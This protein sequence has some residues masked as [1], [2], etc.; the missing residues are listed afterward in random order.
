MGKPT[1]DIPEIEENYPHQ[2]SLL[3]AI[4]HGISDGFSNM[5]ICNW[6][7]SL[8]NSVISNENI[9]DSQLGYFNDGEQTSK[10]IETR[11]QEL[12]QDKNLMDNFIKEQ[13]NLKS[14]TPLL[15]G[16]MESE[17]ANKISETKHIY[18]DLTCDETHCLVKIFKE[19][20]ISFH[21][22]FFA[23]VNVAIVDI[24][25]EAGLNNS[26]Y[27]IIKSHTINFRKYWDKEEQV[28]LGVHIYDVLLAIDTP[29]D[30][31]YNILSYAKKYH[32]IL[33]NV[34]NSSECCN[35]QCFTKLIDGTS[36][37]KPIKDEV[38]K[39]TAYYNTTNMGNVTSILGNKGEHVQI[40]WLTRSVA[41]NDMPIIMLFMPQT[42][43]GRFQIAFG[44]NTRFMTPEIANELIN[45]IYKLIISII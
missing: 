31:K 30:V 45:K 43:R 20:G 5:Y 11:E 32:N 28:S 29:R 27:D 14:K 2:Y 38:K 34:F 22:G 24:L 42:Y 19:N 25:N 9:D 37:Y 15:C 4:H 6:M 7:I 12:M 23:I 40:T 17:T 35:N 36:I 41:I 33:S 18:K 1:S 3:F 13:R 39:P 16:I 21:S 8:L 44:Y 26:N 10:L